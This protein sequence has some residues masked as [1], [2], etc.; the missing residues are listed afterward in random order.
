VTNKLRTHISSITLLDY[1]FPVCWYLV[2]SCMQDGTYDL[3]HTK[4]NPLFIQF[5]ICMQDGAYDLLYTKANALF[6]QLL[7][8]T[9]ST[10]HM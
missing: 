3:F 10:L 2:Y 6:I 4:I 5:Y 7:D 8:G 9:Y 1:V